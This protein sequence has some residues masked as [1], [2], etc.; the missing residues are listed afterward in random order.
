MLVKPHAEGDRIQDAVALVF[1]KRQVADHQL[2][3]QM[4]YL[5]GVAQHQLGIGQPG[6]LKLLDYLLVFDP[7]ILF[8]LIEIKQFLPRRSHVLIGCQ[9]RDKRAERQIAADHQIAADRIEEKRRQLSDEV[10]QEFDKE[11][12]FV[13]FE[14]NVVNSAEQAGEIGQLQFDRVVAVD[15]DY[16]RSR[17]L[18]TVGDDPLRAHALLVELVHLPLQFRDN[19]SLERVERDG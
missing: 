2:A 7:R 10:V 12:A 14:A 6:G 3:L 11:F 9:H 17:F 19:V 4:R 18:D 8:L 13:D 16:T 5:A 15:F 1:S